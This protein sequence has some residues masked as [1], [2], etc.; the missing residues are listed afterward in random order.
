M[1][2]SNCLMSIMCERDMVQFQYKYAN[3]NYRTKWLSSSSQATGA[4]NQYAYLGLT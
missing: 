4:D 3:E 2:C 1:N